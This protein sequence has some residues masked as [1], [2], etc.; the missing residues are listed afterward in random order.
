M[1][2]VPPV[3][4]ATKGGFPE[5]VILSPIVRS[6]HFSC[7]SVSLRCDFKEVRFVLVLLEISEVKWKNVNAS[8]RIDG[9]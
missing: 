4:S 5:F 3:T 1:T 9:K 6:L 2:P 7:F 8:S